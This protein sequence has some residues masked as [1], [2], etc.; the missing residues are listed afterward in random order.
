MNRSILALFSSAGVIALA[1]STPSDPRVRAD[2]PDRASF[3]YV[4]PVLVHRCGT[5]DCHGTPARNLRL[6]GAEG[7]RFA[8]SD[9]PKPKHEV[10]E[11]EASE[12]YASI[13]GLE[14]EVLSAVVADKGASPERLTL[15]RKARGAENHKGGALVRAGDDSDICVTS[16]LAG[17]TDVAA[18]QRGVKR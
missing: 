7:Q 4:A 17:A 12:D 14:P 8:P 9:V 6:Y 18:C 10:T 3:E 1:C 11:E 5:L 15:V 13:V 16:W 2:V